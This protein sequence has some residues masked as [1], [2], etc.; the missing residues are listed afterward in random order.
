MEQLN[1]SSQESMAF[2]LVSDS[3]ERD[4]LGAILR[5]RAALFSTR[6]DGAPRAKRCYAHP[7]EQ[8]LDRRAVT[9]FYDVEL[10]G[11]SEVPSDAL[12]PASAGEIVVVDV[13]SVVGRP[14]VEPRAGFKCR[15]DVRVRGLDDDADRLQGADDLR[16]GRLPSGIEVQVLLVE[17]EPHSLALRAA[18]QQSLLPFAVPLATRP[19]A[20]SSKP[21]RESH[22]GMQLWLV[23]FV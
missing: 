8:V 19:S 10:D 16:P 17:D 6:E 3:L 14:C 9:L 1:G 18:D 11:G 15:D 20:P 21:Q 7:L 12:V 22:L 5:E 2:S 4:D 13:D 23:S